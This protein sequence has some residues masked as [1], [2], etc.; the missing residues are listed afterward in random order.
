MADIR[1]AQ[2]RPAPA[3][4][5][6]PPPGFGRGP[7]HT[8]PVPALEFLDRIRQRSGVPARPQTLDRVVAGDVTAEINGIACMALATFDGLKAAAASGRNLVI[9]LED[10]WWSDNDNLARLEGNGTYKAKRDFI[11]AH[12]MVVARFGDHIADM[13]PNPVAMGMAQQLG[14]L[15]HAA[16]QADPVRFTIAPTTLLDLT[17]MLQTSLGAR[18]LRA[19]GDPKMA[20]SRIGAIWGNAAQMP[21]IHLLNSDIDVLLVGYTREWEAVEYA[22]D[23]VAIGMKK[24]LISLGQAASEQSGMKYFAD[25]LKTIVDEVPVDYVPLAEPYWNLNHPVNLISTKT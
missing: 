13:K 24:G 16:D 10:C 8:G 20:V 18:T 1:I 3:G 17:R 21:S 2:A 12:N 11:R 25:W 9:A 15:D 23:Q 7:A 19:V 14:W 5:G 6:G 22:Q 4:R